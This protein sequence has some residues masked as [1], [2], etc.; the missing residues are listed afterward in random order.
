MAADAIVDVDGVDQALC[1][2]HADLYAELN[3]IVAP[4]GYAKAKRA[5][6]QAVHDTQP[7]KD[8]EPGELEL[9]DGAD[10]GV[11]RRIHARLAG[12]GSATTSAI[13]NVIRD[14]LRAQRWATFNCTSCGRRNRVSIA[15]V[16]TRI[17]TAKL[18]ADLAAPNETANAAGGADWVYDDDFDIHDP[19]VPTR[20]LISGAFPDREAWILRY[21][22]D[23]NLGTRVGEA[24]D[25]HRRWADG[26]WVTDEELARATHDLVDMQQLAE[27]LAPVVGISFATGQRV[28]GA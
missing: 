23:G 1:R 24:L 20:V 3:V 15:D 5:E 17:Q 13:E 27:M 11:M 28:V 19:E 21:H 4:A 26:K 2:F 10:E 25:V 6:R 18:A 22:R 12:L 16:A 8:V 7:L 9:P 14:G